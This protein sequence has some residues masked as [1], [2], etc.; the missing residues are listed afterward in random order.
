[1]NAGNFGALTCYFVFF[2][3]TWHVV[4]SCNELHYL[5]PADTYAA[6]SVELGLLEFWIPTF[7]CVGSALGNTAQQ[8]RCEGSLKAR[9]DLQ[10]LH[11]FS[12]GW[13]ALNELERTSADVECVLHRYAF[14]I[15]CI[16]VQFFFLFFFTVGIKMFHFSFINMCSHAEP[17]DVL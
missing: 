15:C 5:Y 4:V 13:Y 7:Y 17:C 1:M 6:L 16:N 2:T 8:K 14:L 3:T 11:S 10:H 9:L 12:W